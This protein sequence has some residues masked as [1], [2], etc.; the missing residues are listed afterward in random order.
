VR[1]VGLL[2]PARD[3]VRTRQGREA[4]GRLELEED[5]TVLHF[6]ATVEGLNDQIDAVV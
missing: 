1:Q 2:D 3:G 4:V 5:P 6:A